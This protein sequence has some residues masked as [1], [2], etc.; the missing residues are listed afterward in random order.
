MR[1]RDV[2][3]R[4]T[5]RWFGYAVAMMSASMLGEVVK[6]L[7]PFDR[8]RFDLEVGTRNRQGGSLEAETRKTKKG[9]ETM[10][11][12][13]VDDERTTSSSVGDATGSRQSQQG[14]LA[15]DRRKN[16]RRPS[17]STIGSRFAGAPNTDTGS[18]KA[19]GR[20]P[21][22][23]RGVRS[24]SC[25]ATVAIYNDPRWRSLRSAATSSGEHPTEPACAENALRPAWA[26]VTLASTSYPLHRGGK[27]H[28]NEFHRLTQL[29][30]VLCRV[31]HYG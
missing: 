2:H 16:A 26:P 11:K 17:S 6:D 25:A 3:G 12:F 15:A 23:A 7:P 24:I 28:C 9:D 4:G 18:I 1:R 22:P 14:L 30:R 21:D 13:R 31:C 29:A 8:A 27:R 5:A 10:A 19:C 20:R